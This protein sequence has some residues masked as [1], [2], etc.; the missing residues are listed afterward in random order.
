ML[1][2]FVYTQDKLREAS[3]GG[4]GFM[5]HLPE[6]LRHP[7]L[8]EGLLQNDIFVQFYIIEGLVISPF[9]FML[10]PAHSIQT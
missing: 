4:G 8:C 3:Q 9:F 7:S 10:K 1:E 5:T 6:I 2:P